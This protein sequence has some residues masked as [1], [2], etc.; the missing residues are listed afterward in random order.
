MLRTKINLSK[1]CYRYEQEREKRY[2]ED[3]GYEFE[4]K[5]KPAPRSH[6]SSS[7]EEIRFRNNQSSSLEDTRFRNHQSSS[8]EEVRFRRDAPID[9]YR[10]HDKYDPKRRSMFSLIEEEHRK[11]SNEIAK[12]LKRRSYMDN[13]N[14]E[15][16][17]FKDRSYQELP[18]SERYQSGNGTGN[19]TGN[20]GGNHHHP[21][22]QHQLEREYD[23]R[24]TKSSVDIDKIGGGGGGGDVNN[25][26]D[27]KY[28]KNQQKIKSPSYRHSY[29]EPKI[30]IEQN[31][32]KYHHHHPE[33]LHRTNSSVSNNGRVGIASVHPY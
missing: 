10:S 25:K 27:G 7:I 8:T 13:N 16:E 28:L 21:Q 31:N 15:D 9:R 22:Q 29:A 2:Y 5:P 3:R 18:E 14:Y 12:E 4:N 1:I 26:Y 11:N 24:F 20:G 17:Y 6:H 33:L 23:Y 19:G 30:R 32:K